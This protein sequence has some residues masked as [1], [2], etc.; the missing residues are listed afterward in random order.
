MSDLKETWPKAELRLFDRPRP[1]GVH[2]HNLT[3]AAAG[4]GI[5]DQSIGGETGQSLLDFPH[6]PPRIGFEAPL[7]P[8][9]WIFG[10]NLI[11]FPTLDE[12][13]CALPVRGAGR[14][15]TRPNRATKLI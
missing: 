5:D 7:R 14:S 2:P 15:D 9:H 11:E 1:G 3:V 8:K 13:A 4:A 12:I 10:T 6:R